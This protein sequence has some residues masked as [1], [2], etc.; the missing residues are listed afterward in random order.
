MRPGPLPPPS[1]PPPGGPGYAQQ[2]MATSGLLGSPP[3]GGG[4][5]LY[6][7]QPAA[8]GTQPAAFGAFGAEQAATANLLGGTPGGG[9]GLYS[10]QPAAYG[11]AAPGSPGQGMIGAQQAATANLLGGTPGGAV[12]AQQAAI[13][14]LLGGTPGGAIGAQ[15][16]ATANLLGG[17]PGAQANGVAPGTIGAQQ[18]ATQN[19]LGNPGYGGS[20]A[21][22]G[23][24]GTS[25]LLDMT[26][27]QLTPLGQPPGSSAF[28]QQQA[29]QR[30]LGAGAA[31]GGIAA[32]QEA[33]TRLLG[34]GA[35]TGL[36]GDA[37]GG[38]F[39]SQ[40]MA[41]S[42][43]VDAMQGQEAASR[44]L[45]AVE[46]ADNR[47]TMTQNILG[48]DGLRQ[49]GSALGDRGGFTQ[50]GR[51]S[52]E[53]ADWNEIT[54]F[55]LVLNGEIQ[56][57]QLGTSG[58]GP[59]MCVFSMQHG[60][61][62]TVVSGAPNG[63]TQ[64]ATSSLPPATGFSSAILRGG[65]PQEVVWNFPIGLAL[66]STSPFG[67]PRIVVTVYGTDMCNRRVIK[68]YGS[69][70]VPC[71]PGRHTRT[72]RLYC[73]V[74][75]SPL[76]RLLGALFG[77]PAQLVDPRL[78]AGPEGREVVR[79]QSGGKVTVMFDVLLKDTEPF[80]YAF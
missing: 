67:W 78:V 1:E 10:A 57:A 48:A 42:G 14:N 40:Q 35:G 7:A 24:V 2:Q 31:P 17:T 23:A 74:S 21:P 79:V 70:H 59:L 53:R 38:A 34:A 6:S 49:R 30:L 55:G 50:Y 60:A 41:T 20:P 80:N 47:I 32:Q 11:A 22:Y 18:A 3:G 73:P 77:N 72:I 56:S 15:Q 37:P 25:G 54:R 44:L 43:G 51:R 8:F 66:K 16:A 13:A 45:A 64:L 5:G 26:A 46:R 75:S 27:G 39:A 19:L 69:V 65:N 62:W 52:A 61:D 4:S 33:T 12:G 36:L 28:A 9:S 58:R 68:G 76:T 71:Q 63:I 29:T